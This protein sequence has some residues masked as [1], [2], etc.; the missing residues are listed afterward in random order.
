VMTPT[1]SYFLK[2]AAGIDKGAHEPGHEGMWLHSLL[3]DKVS[4]K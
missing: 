1:A 3:N 2:K 4:N